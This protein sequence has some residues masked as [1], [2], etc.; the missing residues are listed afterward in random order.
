VWVALTGVQTPTRPSRVGFVFGLSNS[1]P[2]SKLRAQTAN[3][4]FSG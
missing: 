4:E 2:L 3:S 1:C